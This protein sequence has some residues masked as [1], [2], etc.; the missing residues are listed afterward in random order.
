MTYGSGS[1]QV[2]LPMC[3]RSQKTFNNYWTRIYFPSSV[4]KLKKSNV[5]NWSSSVSILQEK[6]PSYMLWC[7]W[8][9][10]HLRVVSQRVSECSRGWPWFCTIQLLPETPIDS[11]LRCKCPALTPPLP[12]FQMQQNKKILVKVKAQP[13][14]QRPAAMFFYILYTFMYF[15][16]FL[17]LP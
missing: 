5:T 13:W 3:S 9:R 16:V 8:Q 7:H 10:K 11:K 15:I 14:D 6:T 1:N 17:N 2:H 4:W 12:Y